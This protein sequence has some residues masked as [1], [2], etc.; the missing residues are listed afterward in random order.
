MLRNAADPNLL[1]K[2][3][4]QIDDIFEHYASERGL[5]NETHPALSGPANSAGFWA[6]LKRSHIYDD[7]F[8]QFSGMSFYKIIRTSG[9]WDLAANAFPES[10]VGEAEDC[11]CRRTAIGDL[12]IFFDAPID[13]HV[14]AQYH[15]I[16]Q[17]SINFWTPLMACGKDAQGLKVVLLGVQGTKD[18]LEF[19]EAGY[20]KCPD[21][22]NRMHHFR[23]KKR[24]C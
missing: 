22:I 7:T 18:Y 3:R 6:Q 23:C 11:N 14:D 9:L 5:E 17:L 2:I 4:Q 20:E 15:S 13:F 1:D 24:K 16:N 21:D 12:A 19:N 10:V 8:K